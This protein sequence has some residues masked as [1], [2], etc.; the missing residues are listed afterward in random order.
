VGKAVLWT[1]NPTTGQKVTAVTIQP[2]PGSLWEATS[3][4]HVNATTGYL[5]WTQNLLGKA[6]VW[7][8]NPTTGQRV[9]A[10]TIQSNPGFLWEA[11][12]YVY[13]NATTGYLL[14]TNRWL[15][16]AAVWTINPTTGKK[17]KEVAVSP[18]PGSPW[19]AT[20]YVYVNATTGQVLWTRRD[21][22]KATLWTIDPTTGKKRTELTIQPTIGYPWEATSYVAQNA[23]TGALLWTRSDQ[24]RAALWTINLTTGQRLSAVALQ[25]VQ[26]LPW[27]ASSYALS[28][29]TDGITQIEVLEA[30][31]VVT[32]SE[33]M[34]TPT[35]EPTATPTP[36]PEPTVTPIPMVSELPPALPEHAIPEP[37]TLILVGIGLFGLL[38]LLQRRRGQKK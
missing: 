26:G 38:T 29:V 33:L 3:Y 19:A 5:L 27:E 7:T 4:I 25:P 6:A 15:G 10:V 30:T 22:G 2:N 8:I 11:T 36:T 31:S 35:P 24:G 28:G 32:R 16:K 34:A 1:F 21:T 20:S 9:T 14:W 18:S 23:T 17:L 13:G 37:T 12:S